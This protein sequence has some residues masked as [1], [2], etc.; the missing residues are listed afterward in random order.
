MIFII[1]LLIVNVSFSQ[2]KGKT[3]Y[4]NGNYNDARLYYENILRS[5]E[6]DNAAKY[7]LGVSAYKQND[8]DGALSALKETTN[9]DDKVLASKS[10]YNLANILRESGEMEE[11]LEYYKKSIVL[12]PEDKDAKINYE[13]LKQTLKQQ[14]DQQ[15]QDQQ[16]QDQQQQDQQ[17]Q[18]QQQQDQQQQ[19]QQQQDQQQQD[20][21]QQD[22]QEDQQRQNQQQQNQQQQDQQQQDQQQQDQQHKINNRH[23]KQQDNNKINNSSQS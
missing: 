8:I 21:Q 3:A 20:Q 10:Y 17:Q 7:G 13:L 16:Q 9:T 4:E 23:N 18:D 5:R 2:D 14:Q 12:N 6:N 19:D 11:S 22:Q 1:L 15:Q